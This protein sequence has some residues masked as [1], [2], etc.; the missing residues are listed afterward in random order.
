MQILLAN[1]GGIVESNEN[2]I[3]TCIIDKISAE[4]VDMQPFHD[5]GTLK[6]N[7]PP[8]TSI[9]VEIGVSYIR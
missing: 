4:D 7:A 9:I 5:A 1:P 2:A 6:R 8:N 3:P